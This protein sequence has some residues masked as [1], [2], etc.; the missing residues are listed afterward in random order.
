MCSQVGREQMNRS[1]QRFSISPAFLS[2]QIAFHCLLPPFSLSSQRSVSISVQ[3]NTC[4]NNVYTSELLKISRTR[5]RAQIGRPRRDEIKSG[6]V[7]TQIGG[8]K[9]SKETQFVAY[10]RLCF[11]FP[12]LNEC[13][14]RGPRHGVAVALMLSVSGLISIQRNTCNM[15]AEH[16]QAISANLIS[17]HLAPQKGQGCQACQNS[18]PSHKNRHH[19]W[20]W[21]DLASF[22]PSFTRLLVSHLPSLRFFLLWRFEIPSR[23][24]SLPPLLQ[25]KVF[26]GIILEDA[27]GRG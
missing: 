2:F 12:F 20:K 22:I 1:V 7:T 25:T 24:L 19:E 23:C 6:D 9:V 21:I 11:P 16:K 5:P 3:S 17:E 18:C 27:T 4:F 15:L 13:V 8:A 14:R 26:F 10:G